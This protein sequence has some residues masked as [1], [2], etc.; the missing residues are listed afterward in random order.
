MH[1]LCPAEPKVIPMLGYILLREGKTAEA[2][3]VC[4]KGLALKTPPV[5]SLVNL[6]AIRFHQGREGEARGLWKRA[7]AIDPGNPV[8]QVNME[9]TDSTDVSAS[10]DKRYLACP[11]NPWAAACANNIA[12]CVRG[13]SDGE[14]LRLMEESVQ[15]NPRLVRARL[16]LVHLYLSMHKTPQD[17]DLALWH[18]RRAVSLARLKPEDGELPKS[19]LFLGYALVANGKPQEARSVLEEGKSLA[20]GAGVAQFDEALRQLAPP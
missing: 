11:P 7:L 3:G 13:R 2:E 18:A 14:K 15:F 20:K 12:L 5:E 16:N 1:R 17:L 8:A 4:E 19:L 9:R 10:V 6:G